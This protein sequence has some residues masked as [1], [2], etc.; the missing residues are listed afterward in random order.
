MAIKQDLLELFKPYYLFNI[1]L[2]ISYISFKQFPVVCNYVFSK[3][4][5]EFDGVSLITLIDIIL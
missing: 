5:C 4:N 2:S 3:D 1:L